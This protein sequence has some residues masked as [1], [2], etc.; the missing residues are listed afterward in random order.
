M[1]ETKSKNSKIFDFDFKERYWY[2]IVLV[3]TSKN[4]I[5]QRWRNIWK[6]RDQIICKWKF[7]K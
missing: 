1:N 7:G 6:I 4:I 3:H 2:H 5:N